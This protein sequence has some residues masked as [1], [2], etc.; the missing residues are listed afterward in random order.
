MPTPRVRG[1]SPAEI[2]ALAAAW[3]ARLEGVRWFGGKGAGAVV[4]ALDPLPILTP[5]GAWPAVGS[6]VATLAYP[7]GHLEHYH[8]LVAWYPKPRPDA[9]GSAELAGARVWAVDATADATAVRAFVVASQADGCPGMTW[10]HPLADA[11]DLD[12]RVWG[13]E[14]SNTTLVVGPD[15][16]FKLFRRIE[17]GPNL[18]TEVLVALAGASAPRVLGRFQGAWPPDSATDLGVVMERVPGA[19]DGWEIATAAC[20]SEVDFAA[21]ARALGEALHAVHARLADAFPTGV[22]SGDA[23]ADA[24]AG[25]LATAVADAAALAPFA[26]ALRAAPEALRGRDLA[27]QRV[28]GD[29]HLGQTLRNSS[30]WT[31]IDFEGEP[32]KTAAERRA[33]DSVWRDVAGMLRSFDYARSAHADPAS[34]AATAWADACRGAFLAGYTGGAEPDAGVLAAYETD[35]AVY[36]VLYELRNRPAW[37]DIPLRALRE[38]GRPA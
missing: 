17:P 4:T 11:A 5:P 30:G 13:G 27:V 34:D 10:Q 16:L 29:F 19:R 1:G 23:L 31:I 33:P 12:V 35:K 14:Q 6:E 22:Q 25:R 18:D 26:D 37:V 2:A 24:M 32:A 36:E 21:E 28:H 3:G 15:A 7:D 20:A 38:V 9:L 8:L